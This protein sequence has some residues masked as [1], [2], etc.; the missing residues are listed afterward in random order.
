MHLNAATPQEGTELHETR[1]TT[2][3]SVITEHVTGFPPFREL[4]LSDP[5][6]TRVT[7]WL[8]RR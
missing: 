1:D 2:G 3:A 8:F 6:H 7:S 5:L 4:Y